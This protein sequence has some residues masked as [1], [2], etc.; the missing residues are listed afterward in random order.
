[1]TDHKTGGVFRGAEAVLE[2]GILNDAR[3][4]WRLFRDPRVA[5]R[6]KT[7]L[8]FVAALY[9]LSPIDLIPDF[10]LGLG[11]IDDIGLV[12]AT[13]L[14]LVRLLPR[15]APAEIV[16]EHRRGMGRTEQ[17]GATGA[18]HERA[19]QI[20]DA[21]FRVRDETSTTQPPRPAAP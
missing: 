16:A 9:L 1:M 8:P 2:P 20:V 19:G 18:E 15:L 7:A 11:Q 17:T 21:E 10:L 4:A 12:G 6:L 5:S 13:L 14:V 3:L